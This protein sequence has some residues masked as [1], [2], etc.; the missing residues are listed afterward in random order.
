[1]ENEEDPWTGMEMDDDEEGLPKE[2]LQEE[3]EMYK[4]AGR[5]TS[6]KEAHLPVCMHLSEGHCA[7][8]SA[9]VARAASNTEG[10]KEKRRVKEKERTCHKCPST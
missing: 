2:H 10:R 3:E 6:R 7:D 1:M 8:R 4:H 5:K 9:G